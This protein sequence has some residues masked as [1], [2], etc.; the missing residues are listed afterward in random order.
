MRRPPSSGPS[1]IPQ[2]L[3]VLGLL[4]LL[5]VSLV[6]GVGMGAAGIGTADMFRFLW[7]G[8]TG[9]T[10]HADDFAAYTIV[11]EIRLP[12]VVFAAAVGGG[13][14]AVDVAVQAMVRMEERAAARKPAALPQESSADFNFPYTYRSSEEAALIPDAGPARRHTHLASSVGSSNCVN[15]LGLRTT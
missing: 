2:P 8:V 6:F 4:L 1:R 10:V 11:W 7:A 13:L 5:C 9:G 14:S 3:L 12:R 15:F